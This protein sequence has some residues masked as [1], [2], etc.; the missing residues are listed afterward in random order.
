MPASMYVSMSRLRVDPARADELVAAFHR[1]A[2]LVEDA[3]G[4]VDLEV[5]R[6]DRDSGEIVMVSRWR[7]RAAFRDYMR[8]EAHAI[9]HARIDPGLDAAIKLERLEHLHTYEVVAR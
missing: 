7:D 9:S 8:S 2:H 6:S 5:W 4:F 3:P 1:R